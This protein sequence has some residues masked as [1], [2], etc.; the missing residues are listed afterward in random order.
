MKFRGFTVLVAL[1]ITGLLAYGLWNVAVEPFRN[2]VGLGSFISMF[3]ALGVALGMDFEYMRT[4]INARVTA[5][6]FFALFL[7]VNVLF[8]FY[9]AST[10]VYIVVM[11]VLLAVF[12]G[13]V[14]GVLTTRQ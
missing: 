6:F 8:A 12:V 14:N 13:I 10:V 1:V 9:S 11:G 4:A 5:G 7:V 3:A 2:V